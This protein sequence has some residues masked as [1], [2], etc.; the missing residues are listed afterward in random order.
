MDLRDIKIGGKYILGPKIGS[1][2]F[3][4]VYLVNV[5]GT[6]EIYALKK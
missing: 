4:E 6:T 3:G 5:A 2:S 1:G